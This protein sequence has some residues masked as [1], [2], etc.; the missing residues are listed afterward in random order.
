MNSDTVVAIVG[1]ILAMYAAVSI[2]ANRIFHI[3]WSIIVLEM[4][5]F[6]NDFVHHKYVNLIIPV[7]FTVAF[8]VVLIREYSEYDEYESIYPIPQ[9]N[10]SVK[11]SDE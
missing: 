10:G 3:A 7:A 6:T 1:G 11:W 5:L 4:L 2:V 8:V 9:E